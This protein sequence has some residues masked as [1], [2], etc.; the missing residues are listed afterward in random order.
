MLRGNVPVKEMA[1]NRPTVA[2]RIATRLFGRFMV[3]TY[4]YEP[5]FLRDL[6]LTI[7]KSV[8]IPV[9]YI[10]GVLS[11]DHLEKLMEDG[12][13]FIQIGRATIR[14]LDYPKEMEAGDIDESDCD[15]C[16]RCVAAMDGGGVICV[17]AQE[18]G[19]MQSR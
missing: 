5:L 11:R 9:I 19:V 8:S 17:T 7:M 4:P 2:E 18:D 1:V 10:G 13:R 3:Q 6:S 12:F 16:N 15:I 14:N